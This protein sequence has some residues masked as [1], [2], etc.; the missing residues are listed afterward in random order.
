MQDP[1]GDCLGRIRLRVG[2]SEDVI[3]YAGQVGY[4][5]EP[6]HRGHRYAERAC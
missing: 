4:V 6:A 2:W 3:R 1:G 5:V